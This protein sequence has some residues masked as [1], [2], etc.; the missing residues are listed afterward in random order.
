MDVVLVVAPAVLVARWSEGDTAENFADAGRA[1]GAENIEVVI[2]IVVAI[3]G[4]KTGGGNH[5]GDFNELVGIGAL[6]S[7]GADGGG[8][9]LNGHG[10]IAV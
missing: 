6:V 5:V 7:I 2:A 9:G 10:A 4:G 1:N 3:N 8:D